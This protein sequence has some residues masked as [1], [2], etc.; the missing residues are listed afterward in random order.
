MR[1]LRSHAGFH[2]CPLKLSGQINAAMVVF[3][4]QCAAFIKQGNAQF[5]AFITTKEIGTANADGCRLCPEDQLLVLH[6]GDTPADSPEGT[7][8]QGDHRIAAAF[9]GNKSKVGDRGDG[10]VAEDDPGVV[11]ENQFETGR[12]SGGQYFR[13]ENIA[14]GIKAADQAV[15]RCR[16]VTF[17]PGDNTNRIFCESGDR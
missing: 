9:R 14:A 2:I 4:A 17:Q 13:Q 12:G 1:F 5:A 16:C 6:V 10:L 3:D 7:A 8:Q 11:G 15:L